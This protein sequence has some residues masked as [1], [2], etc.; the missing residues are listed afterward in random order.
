MM[1]GKAGGKSGDAKSGGARS[2]GATGR[3]DKSVR[4]KTA[5]GRKLSSTLWLQ[6]QLN[7]PYVQEA[8]RLGYRSRAAF[9][10]AELD[11]RL[12]FL[13]PG[14]TVIDLGAAPGGWSQVAAER[15]K[16]V[17]GSGQGKG[18]VVGLDLL[19]IEP[20]AGVDLIRADFMEDAALEALA[21]AAPDGADAVVSDL[22]PP[23]T[24][25]AATDHLRIMAMAEAAYDFARRV[26]RPGGV[27]I[28]KVLQG[29]TERDLLNNLKR[30]FATVKHMKP[31]SSRQDS[32]ETYV[33]AQGF[34]GESSGSS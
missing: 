29:G 18:K 12:Q 1:A 24:G 11:D 27:F 26:L 7:D 25:H 21:E 10:L 19:E 4:V 2:G 13:K 15:T 3:R 14:L 33:V 17:E 32:R 20:I 28:A 6:R 30:D 23:T 16:S 8:R 9:K 22:A 31:P 5:R 34:R